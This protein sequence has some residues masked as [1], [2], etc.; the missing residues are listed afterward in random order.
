MRLHCLAMIAGMAASTGA[1]ASSFVTLPAQVR[2]SSPSIVH[3]G[4]AAPVTA[5]ASPAR[6]EATTPGA[7]AAAVAEAP[8]GERSDPALPT[9]VALRY[10][11]P[12]PDELKPSGANAT[13]VVSRSVI[14]MGEPAVEMFK[15]AAVDGGKRQTPRFALA[16][17]V[18]R[19]GISGDAF[20]T[21]GPAPLVAVDSAPSE[22]PSPPAPRRERAR[23]EAVSEEPAPAPQPEALPPPPKGIAPLRGV[24]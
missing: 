13:L 16:P 8:E 19:G 11:A 10:P 9:E 23:Q 14:A 1:S 12:V 17:L 20:G 15:V 7:G 18:I 2:P 24:Q 4:S 6:L 22:S 3:L 21:P 5:K